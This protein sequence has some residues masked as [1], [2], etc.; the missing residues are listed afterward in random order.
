MCVR[1]YMVMLSFLW[2]QGL[3][4]FPLQGAGVQGIKMG[5]QW[6]YR[7][8]GVTPTDCKEWLEEIKA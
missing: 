6:E 4:S 7:A 5:P 8:P 1:G 2:N 3:T